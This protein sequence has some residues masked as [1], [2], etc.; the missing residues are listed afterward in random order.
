MLHIDTR[1]TSVLP[2]A[3]PFPDH[4]TQKGHCNMNLPFSHRPGQDAY[5]HTT[6]AE[7]QPLR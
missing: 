1:K 4:W 3:W 2:V 6:T 7:A 5:I